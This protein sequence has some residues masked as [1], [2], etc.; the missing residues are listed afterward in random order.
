MAGVGFVTPF[1]IGLALFIV[2]PIVYALW[3]TFFGP[4]IEVSIK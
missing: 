3:H 2:A 4:H 1:M